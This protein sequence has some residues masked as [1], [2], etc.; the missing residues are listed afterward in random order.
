MSSL[1]ALERHYNGDDDLTCQGIEV[2]ET[3]SVVGP[4]IE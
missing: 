4:L 1:S 3:E 2:R